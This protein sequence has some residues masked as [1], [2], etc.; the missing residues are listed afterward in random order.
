M[1]LWPFRHFGLKLLSFGLAVSLWMVVAGEETVERGLR[2]PLELQQFPSGLELQGEPPSTVDI[3]VRGASGALGRVS[4]GDIVAV[5]DL[6]GARPGRRIYHMTPEQVRAP[7]GLE[8]VQVTPATVA[9]L[10]EASVSRMLPIEPS[11]EG[12]PAPGYVAGKAMVEPKIVEIVGPESAVKR[13]SEALTEPVSIDGARERVRELVTIGV[14]DPT[15]RIKTPRSATVTVPVLAARLEHTVRDV[16]VVLR[17]LPPGLAA[18]A[19]PAVVTVVVRG[20][21]E[22]LNRLETDDVSAYVDLA[23]LG[24]GQYSL[25]VRAEASQ[26]AGVAR[27]DPSNVQ[28]RIARAK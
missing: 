22:G 6:R 14:L 19:V 5:L 8:I 15:L 26:D 24:A 27:I 21:R 2:V 10:F 25:T 11:V 18:D 3:R 1:T 12:R 7:F 20:S 13:A 28:V 4:P 23:G 9:M 17:N 16:P